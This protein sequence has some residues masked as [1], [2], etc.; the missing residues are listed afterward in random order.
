[1]VVRSGPGLA[2]WLGMRSVRAMTSGNELNYDV[3]M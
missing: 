2:D 3:E 1:M